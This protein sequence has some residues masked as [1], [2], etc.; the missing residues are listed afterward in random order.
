MPF[1]VT[2]KTSS[3]FWERYRH[4]NYP[5]YKAKAP[6]SFKHFNYKTLFLSESKIWIVLWV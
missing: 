4:G 3:N 1:S 5:I 6:R 2:V